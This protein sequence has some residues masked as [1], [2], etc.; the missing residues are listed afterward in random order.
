[1]GRGDEQPAD[2]I[3]VAGLHP[4]TPLAATLLRAIGRQRHPLD[5]AM[6]RHRHHH[7]LALDQVLVLDLAFLVDDHGAARRC[8]LGFDRDQLFLDDRLDARPRPQ[9]LQIVGDLD[10]ELVEFFGNFVTAQRR[11]ALQ[12]QIEDRLGLLHRQ[13]RGAVL[14]KAMPGIVDQ[15]D[16]RR[17]VLGRPVPRH[18]G[19]ASSGRIRRG[20]DHADDLVDV[21][22][23]DGETD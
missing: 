7:V 1:M 22:N 3:L 13:P 8:E 18:Q 11:Q 2:E 20:A 21:G 12:A 19:I 6:V 9:D 5:V 17:D 23:R 14:G 15:R 10:R 4:R 16:H